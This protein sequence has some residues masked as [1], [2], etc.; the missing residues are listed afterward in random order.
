MQ[1]EIGTKITFQQDN[2]LNNTDKTM[3]YWLQD[4]HLTVY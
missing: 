2:D 3:L 1:I 4:K